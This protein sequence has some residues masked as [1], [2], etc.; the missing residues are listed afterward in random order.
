MTNKD[1]AAEIESEELKR[2]ERLARK[3][4][5]DEKV[6]ERLE[7]LAQLSIEDTLELK[8]KADALNEEFIKASSVDFD[9]D[10]AQ[11]AVKK[12]LDYTAYALHKLQGK[13][14]VIDFEMCTN[15]ANSIA[16]DEDKKAAFNQ[17][18]ENLAEHFSKAMHHYAEQQFTQK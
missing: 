16:N 8:E 11:E 9:S 6:D 18:G 15:F 3:R 13:E 5:G 7:Q 10:I 14:L 4:V 2:Q 17:F 1:Q 12:Y